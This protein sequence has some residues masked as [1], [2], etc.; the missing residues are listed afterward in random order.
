MKK[1]AVILVNGGSLYYL[2]FITYCFFQTP[3]Y[4]AH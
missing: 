1:K 2:S 4:T 3:E